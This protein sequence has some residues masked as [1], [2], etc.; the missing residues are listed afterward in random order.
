MLRRKGMPR[1]YTLR[2]P[3][4]KKR[5]NICHVSSLMS[6]RASVVVSAT[7]QRESK[8]GLAVLARERANGWDEEEYEL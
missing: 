1:M 5:P 4:L 6:A 2:C 8:L 7:Q 3:P